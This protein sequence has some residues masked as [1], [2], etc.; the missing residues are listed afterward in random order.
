MLLLQKLALWVHV[1]G[2]IG[3]VGALAMAQWGLPRG[4]T[5]P[6]GN[7]RLPAQL[8]GV[9]FVA[10][11]IVLGVTFHIGGVYPGYLHSVGTKFVLLL[12]S[13]A[14]LGIGAKAERLG[15]TAK[16][17]TMRRATL[18]TLLL[19]SLLGALL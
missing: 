8:L 15:H 6:P 13:G 2:M 1:L 16:A 18:A 5:T 19:A 7:F 3:A 12:A 11:L 17:A 14:T 4:H 9:G 10:G